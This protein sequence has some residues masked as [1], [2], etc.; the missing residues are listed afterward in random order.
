M[1][2]D[3][4]KQKT[5]C[6]YIWTDPVFFLA[7]LANYSEYCAGWGGVG[8]YPKAPLEVH[9]YEVLLET[10]VPIPEG[11]QFAEK[12]RAEIENNVYVNMAA[13]PATRKTWCRLVS[14]NMMKSVSYKGTQQ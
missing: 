10:L 11:K 7:V 12:V 9:D 8:E 6:G 4:W 5:S 1:S 13:N 2:K 3:P 14:E